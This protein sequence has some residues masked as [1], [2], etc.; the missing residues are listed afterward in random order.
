[1]LR[2]VQIIA[3]GR[4]GG[5]TT[6]ILGLSQSLAKH[7]HEITIITQDG[8]YLACQGKAVG[9]NTIG[10]DFSARL[11]TFGNAVRLFRQL[12]QIDPTIIH[13]HGAR[14]GL[15]AALICRANAWQ[16][17]YTVHGF[18]FPHKPR[19]LRDLGRSAEALCIGQSDFAVFVSDG[20]FTIAN[21]F[22]LLPTSNRYRIIKNAVSVDKS[23]C[24]VEKLYDIGFVGR[25][26]KPKNPL[27][28]VDILKQMRPGRPSLCVIGGGE[29][30]HALKARIEQ[31]QL[32]DQVVMRGECSRAEALQLASSCRT[33]VLP[34]LWEGHPIV[35]IEALHLG[36]PVVAS[37]IPGNDEIVVEGETGYLVPTFGVIEYADRLTRLLL[38]GALRDRMKECAQ[39]HAAHNY[40]VSRMVD[41]H[42]EMYAEQRRVR[43]IASTRRN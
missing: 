32:G 12:Q 10:L 23:I 5:G 28:L 26:Q 43:T 17:V 30:Q 42:L 13:A 34:S 37:D 33:L 3:D 24:G 36:V 27:I 8:S 41:A 25:L 19:I 1:M 18:H 11:R 31:E 7:G 14:A 2:I 38:N 39:R 29:L 15:P 35:L 21:K 40:S 22:S 20:D 4:P 6:A 9:L 16:F